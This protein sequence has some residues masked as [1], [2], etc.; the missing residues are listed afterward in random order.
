V[1]LIRGYEAFKETN[2]AHFFFSHNL[3][4]LC[5][6]CLC[7]NQIKLRLCCEKCYDFNLSLIAVFKKP[8][9]NRRLYPTNLGTLLFTL[10]EVTSR[11]IPLTVTT[12]AS[13]VF[14][15]LYTLPPNILTSLA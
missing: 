12:K 15:I 8:P 6:N 11:P 2:F 1:R 10:L 14:F 3:R 9:H 7:I 4:C 13:V 5:S